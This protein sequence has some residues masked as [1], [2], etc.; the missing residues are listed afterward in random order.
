METTLNI[1]I[2]EI[3]SI[4]WQIH[5]MFFVSCIFFILLLVLLIHVVLNASDYFQIG[6]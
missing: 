2:A 3:N 4:A 1:L 5:T 6:S